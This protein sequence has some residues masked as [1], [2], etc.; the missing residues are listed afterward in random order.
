MRATSVE[1]LQ[2]GMTLARTIISD[3]MVVILSEGTLLTKA[4][5]TRLGFLTI[6]TVYVK[7]EYELSPSYQNVEAMLRPSNA[8]VAEYKEVI[9]TAKD[10]FDAT[11]KGGTVPMDK[12]ASMVK[13][14]L[15]PMVRQSGVIDYLF[16]LNHLASDVYN[17]SLRVSILAGVIAKWLMFPLEKTQE[18]IL[19][20]FLHDI[21][22]T[23]F[24]TRLIEK[25]I[26]T[27]KGPDLEAYMKHTMDGNHILSES[28]SFSDGIKLAALQ[29]HECMD[30]SGFPF[31]L[32]GND[33]HEYARIIA[34]ADMYDN[35]TVEREG[36]VKQ[37]PFNAIAR[38]SQDMYT[39]LDPQICVPFLT[40]IREAFLGSTVTLSNGLQGT[41]VHYM[42]DLTTQPLVRVSQDVIIDLNKNK[43]I[44]IVEYNSK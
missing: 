12:T 22:K 43:N 5:I 42:E 10:I 14:P 35:I 31:N 32:P 4:H 37:T 8:F 6:P 21:G 36:F 18:L 28:G 40:H 11:T 27:L 2:P 38:I 3:D 29:H 9:H 41:I 13:N 33:I 16:E 30:A 44:T 20:G 7:D 15:L 24:D 19:A 23:K 25:R 26:D 17:H 34:L 1:D 39:R